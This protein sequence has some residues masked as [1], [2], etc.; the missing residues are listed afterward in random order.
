M[1]MTSN[2]SYLIRALYDWI[3]DNQL[4]PYLLVQADYPGIQIPWAYAKEG[5]IVLDI[6]PAACRGL[7]LERD[8][9]VFTARFGGK[10]EQ[11]A[12]VPGAVLA[13]YTKENGQGME[14]ALEMGE[15]P[16]SLTPKTKTKPSLTLV[17]KE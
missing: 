15:P 14:F 11:I 2:K 10:A 7:H 3:V 17:K 9:I 13:I 6:S 1:E 4:T 5:R 12:I 8:R 16:P